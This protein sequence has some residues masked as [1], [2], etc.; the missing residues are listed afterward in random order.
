M[1]VRKT[2]FSPFVFF[3]FACC[4]LPTANCF[5]QDTRPD[6]TRLFP[7]DTLKVPKTR[8]NILKTNPFA[9]L[10]SQVVLAIDSPPI[11][12]LTGELRVMY[13][14]VELPKQSTV[15]G[16]SYIMQS[17]LFTDTVDVHLRKRFGLTLRINGVRL[18]VAQ[19]FYFT[20][21]NSP[22]GLYIAPHASY[23]WSKWSFYYTTYSGT[24]GNNAVTYFF[25]YI[26]VN[27]LFGFQKLIRKKV[28]FDVNVGV[29]FRY[30]FYKEKNSQ[31]IIPI[32][33]GEGTPLP[34]WLKLS[35]TSNFG[36]AF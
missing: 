10:A 21:W 29:G 32:K 3:F 11:P 1:L 12:L 33:L 9:L 6:F 7:H 28:A 13:E 4:I 23:N 27:A 2:F 31:T 20:K 16:L 15:I 18:Q 19:K 5:S 30:N 22:Q 17:P 34:S 14:L 8:L 26:N 35:F 24:R 25:N 36:F